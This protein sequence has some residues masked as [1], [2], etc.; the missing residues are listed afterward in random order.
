MYYY[1][2]TIKS[3]DKEIEIID[4]KNHNHINSVEVKFYTAEEISRGKSNAMAASILVKGNI[5]R[6][7]NKQLKDI[8]DWSKD[9]KMST[10]YRNVLIVVKDDEDTVSRTYDFKQMF[11]TGYRECYNSDAASDKGGEFEL[12]MMQQERNFDS[13]EVLLA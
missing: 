9:F 2:L 12:L 4:D 5:N 10:T 3:S 6:E 7:I 11:V 8:F 13:A 1:E